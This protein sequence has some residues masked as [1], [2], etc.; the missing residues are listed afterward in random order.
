METLAKIWRKLRLPKSLQLFFMRIFEDQFL[1][2]V[3]GIILND[4][5]EILLFKYGY[6]QTQWGLPGGFIKAKEHPQEALEREIEEES[7]FIVSADEELKIRTDRQTA[8]MDI[9]FVGK[10]MGGKFR[11]SSEVKDAKFFSFDDLPLLISKNQLFI[12]EQVLF[13]RKL[14]ERS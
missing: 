7:G 10:L 11:K 8:R 1:I 4:K 13:Q 2:G 14:L 6:R 9:G 12:I 3:T 5:N